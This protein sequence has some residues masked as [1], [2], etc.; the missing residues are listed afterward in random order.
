MSEFENDV[1]FDSEYD[2]SLVLTGLDSI[3]EQEELL[4][5]LWRNP[6]TRRRVVRKMFSPR[7]APSQGRMSS[8]DDFQ[9][10][11]SQLPVDTRKGLLNRSKQ[12]VDTALYVTKEISGSK[13]AKMLQDDDNKVI[14]KSNISGGKLEK[15]NFFTIKGIQLM[16]GVAAETEDYKNVNFGVLPDF[17]RNGEF[18]FVANGS[19][20]IPSMSLEIFN[21]AGMNI[22][23]GYFELVNPKMIETQQPMD[24]EIE[25]GANA[26]DR[27]YMKAVLHGT[28]SSKY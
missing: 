13:M 18:E 11:F 28:S 26:P 23:T 5:R 21:T 9:R 19:I 12:L 27:T 6:K 7:R 20:L 17:I 3:E 14:G 10:R 16:Y 25:W 22:R 15:G 24:L 2:D 4:G 8:R 1:I